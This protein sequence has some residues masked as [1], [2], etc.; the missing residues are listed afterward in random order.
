MM[1][2]GWLL[3][4]ASVVLLH[5]APPVP[6]PGRLPSCF[7]AY[8]LKTFEIQG[9]EL[10]CACSRRGEGSDIP[11]DVREGVDFKC[12]PPFPPQKIHGPGRVVPPGAG[13]PCSKKSYCRAVRRA[14][15]T[16]WAL[17]RGHILL[18]SGQDPAAQLIPTTPSLSEDLV[19][20]LGRPYW[21]GMLE[22]SALPST[23]KW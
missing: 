17:Y 2:H 23:M 3:A 18:G 21:A 12:K 1:F 13:K 22:D 7:A 8:L 11:M 14:G 20:D 16:G 6:I 9:A 19:I 10:C 15:R 5:T 4:L